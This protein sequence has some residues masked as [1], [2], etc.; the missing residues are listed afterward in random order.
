MADPEPGRR[1]ALGVEVDHQDPEA[2]LGE[3]RAEVDG[4]RRLAD[5]ALLVRDREDPG[6]DDGLGRVHQAGGAGGGSGPR[7]G[8]GFG[9]HSGRFCRRCRVLGPGL[10][11]RRL[12]V[13]RHL[14]S[15]RFGHGQFR[16]DQRGGLLRRGRHGLGL[17]ERIGIGFG[18]ALHQVEPSLVLGKSSPSVRAASGDPRMRNQRRFPRRSASSAAILP[19][20]P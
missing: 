12:G 20:D 3:G 10:G 14:G 7:L 5:A 15:V 9:L 8:F 13:L 17:I 4:G 2:E 16:D 18:V 6:Q 19:P 1:V 11:D